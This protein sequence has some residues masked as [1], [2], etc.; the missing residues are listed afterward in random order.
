V[1]SFWEGQLSRRVV[2]PILMNIS[3]RYISD[4][5]L[6]PVHRTLPKNAVLNDFS[7]LALTQPRSYLVVHRASTLAFIVDRER[8]PE[9]IAQEVHP[10]H[11]R[12]APN[13][14]A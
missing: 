12:D 1:R 3:M 6:D 10:Q 4:T 5:E 14:T 2:N 8:V 13:A 9:K 7:R 11:D